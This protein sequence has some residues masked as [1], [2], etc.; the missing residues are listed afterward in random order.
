MAIFIKFAE[1]FTMKPIF[2][3][4]FLIS[5]NYTSSQSMKINLWPEGSIPLS[6]KN[7]IQEQ[8][9]STDIV[10]IGKV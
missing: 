4:L 8:A 9:V 5:A 7:N 10:R 1:H 2:A 6:I 3:F